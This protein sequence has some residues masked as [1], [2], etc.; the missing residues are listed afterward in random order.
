MRTPGR[1]SLSA[2]TRPR[3]ANTFSCAFSRTE[4]VLKRMR[5]A[6]PGS[7]VFSKPSAALS[8]SAIL[9]E[10]YSFI[11]HPKVRMKT[12]FVVMRSWRR[13]LNPGRRWEP[14]KSYRDC[15]LTT[16]LR[17]AAVSGARAPLASAVAHN[18][19][20]LRRRR[21]QEVRGI[22]PTGIDLDVGGAR[23]HGEAT[24]RRER[25]RVGQARPRV[26]VGGGC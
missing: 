20:L 6:S 12:F 5:S 22:D 21:A 2:L 8:T 19:Y 13:R 16:D 23:E 24:R 17:V 1:A 4:Q 14:T 26:E 10:S 7:A 11:W 9:S 18:A 25:H 15:G 3:S